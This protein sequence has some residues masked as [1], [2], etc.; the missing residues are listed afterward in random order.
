MILSQNTTILFCHRIIVETL[1]P[2]STSCDPWTPNCDLKPKPW[3]LKGLKFQFSE[4]WGHSFVGHSFAGN[5]TVLF[6][7]KIHKDAPIVLSLQL[8]FKCASWTV[9]WPFMFFLALITKTDSL[10][11][12]TCSSFTGARMNEIHK[13]EWVGYRQKPFLQ[14]KI[15]HPH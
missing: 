4:K 12:F 15:L 13:M 3:D 6:I 7:L 10:R 9:I 1:F 5:K 11:G 2:A 8:L 14:D